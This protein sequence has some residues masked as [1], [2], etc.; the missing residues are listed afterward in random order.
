[1]GISDQPFLPDYEDQDSS[2]FRRLASLVD[3]QVRRALGMSCCILSSFINIFFSNKNVLF[4]I[5][6]FFFFI[7]QLKLI[8][9]KNSVLAKAFKGSTVQAFRYKLHPSMMSQLVLLMQKNTVGL[10][11]LVFGQ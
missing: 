8:Y 9:S 7:F 1:M 10:A 5:F 6:F 2:Q 3:R 4:M 11:S